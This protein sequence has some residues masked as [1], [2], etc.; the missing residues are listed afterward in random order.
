MATE[1]PW[2]GY[3]GPCRGWPIPETKTPHSWQPQATNIGSKELTARLWVLGPQIPVF[4]GDM[5]TWTVQAAEGH[6]HLIFCYFSLKA[7]NSEFWLKSP[8]ISGWSLYLKWVCQSYLPRNGQ[9]QQDDVS[10]MHQLPSPTPFPRPPC[11]A[12]KRCHP[13]SLPAAWWLTPP[14]SPSQMTFS[15]ANWAQLLLSCTWQ[16]SRYSALTELRS[17]G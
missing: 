1:T 2:W 12:N 17:K 9:Q 5:T 4:L 6:I 15:R 13:G 10:L 3:S 7:T 16:N 11:G 14:V 8:R